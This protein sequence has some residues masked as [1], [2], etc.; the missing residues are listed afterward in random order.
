MIVTLTYFLTSCIENYEKTQISFKSFSCFSV[1]RLLEALEKKMNAGQYFSLLLISSIASNYLTFLRFLHYRVGTDVFP[2]LFLVHPIRKD[3]GNY[4]KPVKLQSLALGNK[5]SNFLNLMNCQIQNRRKSQM[6]T[7][8]CRC[9]KC[10]LCSVLKDLQ[11]TTEI[12]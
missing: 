5:L 2:I 3:I 7:K 4:L 10:Q 11:W 6:T 9:Y 1:K 12:M 8:N